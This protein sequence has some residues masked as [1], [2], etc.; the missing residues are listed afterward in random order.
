MSHEAPKHDIVLVAGTFDRMHA[1][2]EELLD[3]A[4]KTGKQVEVHITDDAMTEAKAKKLG[5]TNM[6]DYA[7][8]AAGVAEL[9]RKRYGDEAASRFSIHPLHDP[10]GPA[11]TGKHYTAIVCSEETKAGCELIN[12][13]RL[14]DHEFSPL[15]IVCIGLQLDPSTGE[16]LSSTALRKQE[17][18]AHGGKGEAVGTSGAAHV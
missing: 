6:H 18:L 1:G 11:V 10:F 7:T 4:F 12:K 3:A 8:R 15:E 5:Q 9:C 13:K 14:E 16:K 17:L 2:H